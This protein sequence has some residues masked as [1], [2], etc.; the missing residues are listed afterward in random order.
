M[1]RALSSSAIAAATRSSRAM[2]RV[3]ARRS[4]GRT[5]R[6]SSGSVFVGDTIASGPFGAAPAIGIWRWAQPELYGPT[7]ITTRGSAA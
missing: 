6:V 2:S 7:S 3:Y 1:P 4:F 5:S